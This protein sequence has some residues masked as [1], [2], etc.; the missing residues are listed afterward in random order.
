[1]STYA[2]P[3]MKPVTTQQVVL[4][5]GMSAILMAG[6]VVMA[7][8]HIDV[9]AI[10]GG[11]ATISIAVMAALGLN[12]KHTVDQVKEISNGRLTAV[13]ADNKE[14]HEKVAA[15]SLLTPPNPPDAP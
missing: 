8:S 1:M 5:L 10:L 12:L 11:V 2:A 6:I 4:I 13:L 7:L 3:E 14:L 9:L 15:L